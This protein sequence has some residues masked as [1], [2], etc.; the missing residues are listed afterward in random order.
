MTYFDLYYAYL[1]YCEQENFL[2]LRD[3]HH[4]FMEWNHTLPQTI[5][6]DL[7]IGQWLTKEQ[8]AVASALQT[9]AFQRKCVCGFHKELMPSILWE[10]CLPFTRT[11]GSKLG[12]VYGKEN[13]ELGRGIWG[14]TPE[15]WAETQRRGGETAGRLAVERGTGIHTE[16]ETLRREWASAGGKKMR[17]KVWWS[18]GIENRRSV[19]EP[20]EGWVRGI[21]TNRWTNK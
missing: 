13:V 12:E 1:H 9:L 15:Q 2:N 20:A 5:F 16:D 19:E 14:Q 18:N 17:G 6:G 10:L 8:H 7:P 21:I 3:P 4:D 11:F